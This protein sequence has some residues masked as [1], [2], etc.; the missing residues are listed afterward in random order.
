MP[1]PAESDSPIADNNS[2]RLSDK[3]IDSEQGDLER[4]SDTDLKVLQAAF[5]R[6]LWYS[7]TL[8]A[9]VTIIGEL[10]IIFRQCIFEPLSTMFTV[11]LPMFFS[12]Y[13]FSKAFFTFWIAVSM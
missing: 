1:P 3:P 2:I 12:H 5:K 10:G 9:I 7:S 11:P 4:D 8:T 6:A 13:I